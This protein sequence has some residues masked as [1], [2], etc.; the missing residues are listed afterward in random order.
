ML[1]QLPRLPLQRLRCPHQQCLHQPRP[2]RLLRRPRPHQQKLQ[3]SPP[4]LLR[5]LLL[6]LPPNPQ[7][8]QPLHLRPQQLDLAHRQIQGLQL[9]R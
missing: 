1:Q 9:L 4:E 3:H 8:P 2:L 5:L 7:P 6:L